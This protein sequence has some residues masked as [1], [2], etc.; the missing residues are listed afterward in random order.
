VLGSLPTNG[1]T[2]T[3]DELE[4]DLGDAIVESVQRR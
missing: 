3:L 2:P 4:Q 1:I